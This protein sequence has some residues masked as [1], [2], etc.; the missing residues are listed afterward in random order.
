MPYLDPVG[1]LTVGYGHMIRQGED[2][3]KGL[4]K[5]QALALLKRDIKRYE[6][7]VIVYVSTPLN[8]NQ[9]DALV[10]FVFNIGIGA[11]RKSTLLVKLNAGDYEGAAPQFNRWTK[12]KVEGEVVSL[13]GLVRRRASERAL[14]SLR[15][16]ES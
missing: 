7:A 4:T 2:F 14:F 5:E 16:A 13:P 1:M 6:D 10:S 15:V 9:F 11:F 12:G 8:Q 3:S